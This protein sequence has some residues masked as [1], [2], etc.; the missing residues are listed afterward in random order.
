[1]TS[2]TEPHKCNTYYN[3]SLKQNTTPT[4]KKETTDNNVT[5]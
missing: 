3:E 4:L 5:G 1:M 2:D